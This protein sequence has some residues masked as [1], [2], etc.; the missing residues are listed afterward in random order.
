MIASAR[1]LIVIAAR[2]ALAPAASRL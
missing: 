1:R 2:V